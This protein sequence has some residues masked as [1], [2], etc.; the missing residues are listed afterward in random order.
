MIDEVTPDSSDYIKATSA[1]T[2]EIALNAVTDPNTSA[3]QFICYQAW[4]PTG[5][6]LTVQLKQGATVI[7][8]W[9]HDTLPTTPTI[10]ERSLTGPQCDAITDYANLRIAFVAA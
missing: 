7:A 9:V 6:A 1:G 8:S 5:G 4:S 3:N 2:A 10:Y